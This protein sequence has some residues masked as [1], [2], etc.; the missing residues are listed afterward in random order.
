[1][2]ELLEGEP[3]LE[4]ISFALDVK[5]G[6]YDFRTNN[7]MKLS[8][9]CLAELQY[10]KRVQCEP[11]WS[12]QGQDLQSDVMQ[13]RYLRKVPKLLMHHRA[14][15][16]LPAQD[17]LIDDRMQ[18]KRPIACQQPLPNQAR[19]HAPLND[20]GRSP[21][22][23]LVAGEHMPGVLFGLKEPRYDGDLPQG[24]RAPGP[25]YGGLCATSLRSPHLPTAPAATGH[26]VNVASITRRRADL[27]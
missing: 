21:P 25:V 27:A 7:I 13:L 17:G 16:S 12:I 14:I 22:H 23:V 11:F 6:T 20:G 18:L 26:I 15:G 2:R 4:C 19:L 1:M 5:V 3:E 8:L 9:V 24:W 10:L